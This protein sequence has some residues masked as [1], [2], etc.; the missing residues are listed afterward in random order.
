[1]DKWNPASYLKFEYE[2]T[3]PSRD[4]AAH[5]RVENARNIID[6]GCGP[7]NS[8]KV[9]QDTWPRARIVGL[10]SSAQ[11]IAAAR[12]TYPDREWIVDD[13]QSWRSDEQFDVVF[14]NAALQWMAD[15]VQV[16]KNLFRHLNDGGALAVQ[17]PMI[18]DSPVHRALAAVSQY[19][20][21]EKLLR[22]AGLS[23]THYDE[24]FYYNHL[25]TMTPRIEMWI[26]TYLHVMESHQE[27]ID[28]YSST[29]MRPFLERIGDDEQRRKFANQ[30]L[31]VCKPEYPIQQN[32]MVMFPFKRLF[33]VARKEP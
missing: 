1:L 23:R 33:F 21:W 32:G 25:A 6:I 16:L 5:I 29:G 20:E 12:A 22:G 15:Q 11:M 2:R 4:L 13:A 31:E 30:V 3:L 10:D 7:G 19:A 28:W 8:T 27:I 26:T 18:G 24:S 17:V 14:S 9:L